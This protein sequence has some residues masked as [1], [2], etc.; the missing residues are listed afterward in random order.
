M[1]T[2]FRITQEQ[3]DLVLMWLENDIYPYCQDN[4]GA[5]TYN[6]TEQADRVSVWAFYKS[7]YDYEEIH[8]GSLTY[9]AC[10]TY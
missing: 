10:A 7:N 3:R 6:F 9:D 5:V 2:V 4:T 8:L 1:T